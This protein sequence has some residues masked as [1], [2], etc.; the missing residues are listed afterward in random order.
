MLVVAALG[1]NALLRRGEPL[2]AEAQRTNVAG[3]ADALAQII[4]AGH[5]LVITHGNGPQIGLLALQG[6]A[7]K[8]DESFPLDV[9]GAETDGMIGYMIEQALE[10]ALGHD[11]AV[12]TL[13]TQIE[14]D[15]RDPAFDRPTKFIGPVYDKAE[16]ERLAEARGWS[17]AADGAHWRRVVPSPMPSD[18]PDLKVL[19]LLLSH[20]VTLICAGGGGIPVVRRPDGSLIGIEA[21]I[22]KDH[23]TALLAH[24]L[25]ADA[26]LLLTD[27][28]AVF[29]DFGTDTQAAIRQMS[30]ED[31]AR[32]D[33]PDGSMA[34]KVAAAATFVSGRDRFASVGRLEDALAMLEGRAGTMIANT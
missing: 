34:P 1:G 12:A 11:R 19:Q 20:D 28:A 3:A 2:T 21:V 8:P 30:P 22:D 17:I 5:K 32:L 33:L 13:L 7:Y 29:R 25:G 14:V 4:R 16:A 15:P 6:A 9:L 10:N 23:A 31:A 18:I 27:V 26:L 24:K